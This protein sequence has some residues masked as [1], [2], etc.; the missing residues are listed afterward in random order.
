MLGTGTLGKRQPVSTGHLGTKNERPSQSPKAGLRTHFS[1]G[2]L[3]PH[4]LPTPPL[5]IQYPAFSL[6]L[7]EGSLGQ[8]RQPESCAPL[9]TI[10]APGV[11]AW[12]TFTP[13]YS[14]R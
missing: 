2:A 11:R 9:T 14:R 6:G 8:S 4:P 13:S 7:G 5:H 12:W 3:R 10:L 1:P